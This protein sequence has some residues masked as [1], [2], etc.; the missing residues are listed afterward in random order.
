[1]GFYMALYIN[2]ELFDECF[3]SDIELD[4]EI[5]PDIFMI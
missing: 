4:I 1:M 3:V 2:F 5:E